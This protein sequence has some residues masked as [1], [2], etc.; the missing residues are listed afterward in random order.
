MSNLILVPRTPR[1]TGVPH[2]L[3]HALVAKRWNEDLK[4][5]L[6]TDTHFGWSNTKPDAAKVQQLVQ[7]GIDLCGRL[8]SVL[9]MHPRWQGLRSFIDP[10]NNALYDL[11][12]VREYAHDELV[13][14]VYRS[15][16]AVFELHTAFHAFEVASDDFV[17]RLVHQTY[18][19]LL[20][21]AFR[22]LIDWRDSCD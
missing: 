8:L 11:E 5:R 3:A 13:W 16:N 14:Y 6:W 7:E 1:D 12:A 22:N 19:P 20:Q 17:H 9:E 15:F 2:P 4:L 21:V 18:E 10:I